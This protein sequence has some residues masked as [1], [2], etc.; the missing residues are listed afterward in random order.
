MPGTEDHPIT[1]G[2]AGVRVRAE[3]HGRVY[4]DSDR[5]LA[6]K[7]A[8]YPTVYYV[9]RSDV[10]M[11]WLEKSDTVTH[12]PFKGD[13]THYTAITPQGAHVED[14]MWSYESPKSD[15]A[16]I[17]GYFAVYPDKLELV[18]EM[19]DGSDII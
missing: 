17:E 16:E 1:I 3:A 14:A 2:P 10:R 8:G 13:A 7:E 15:M 9:P 11:D 19:P 5:A 6:V 12:C 18:R 4:M